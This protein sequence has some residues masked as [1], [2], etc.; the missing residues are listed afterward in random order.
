[1]SWFLSLL[2]LLPL[3]VVVEEM[4]FISVTAPILKFVTHQNA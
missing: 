3:A 2:L 1:M 4:L